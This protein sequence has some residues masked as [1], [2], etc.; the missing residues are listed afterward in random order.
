VTEV[1]TPCKECPLIEECA[2]LSILALG[3]AMGEVYTEEDYDRMFGSLSRRDRR[4]V[5]DMEKNGGMAPSVVDGSN[6]K[7][8]RKVLQRFG[9]LACQGHSD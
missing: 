7:G 6:C 2:K 8:P 3:K 1:F 5:E 9:K 4:F